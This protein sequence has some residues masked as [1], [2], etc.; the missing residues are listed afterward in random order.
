MPRGREART[1][2]T[3][4]LSYARSAKRR[5]P[6]A[7]SSAVVQLYWLGARPKVLEGL[8]GPDT[9]PGLPKEV[10]RAWI[11]CSAARDPRSLQRIQALLLGHPADD[12]ARLARFLG[13]LFEWTLE[14]PAKLSGRK[15]RWPQPGFQYD[16][17]AWLMLE[18]AA[19]SPN[20]STRHQVKAVLPAFEATASM[21]P[22]RRVLR[23]IQRL[24]GPTST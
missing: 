10:A 5:R 6:L 21:L 11:A 14:G 3:L 7:R 17:R 16:A 20:P 12:V 4:A 1:L 13:D 8:Y 23:R 2:K 19:H 18:L 15:S 24:I 9:A 22:E